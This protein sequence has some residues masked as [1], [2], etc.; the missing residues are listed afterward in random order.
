MNKI[1]KEQLDKI[2]GLPPY[3]DNTT[4]LIIPKSSTNPNDLKIGN[5]YVLKLAVYI[6]NPPSGFLLADQWNKGIT[7]KSE[8]IRCEV[9]QMMGKMIRVGAIGYDIDTDTD[10]TDV[11]ESLWLPVSGVKIVRNLGAL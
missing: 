1:I 6:I 2:E 9:L 4:E 3:D 11:Y 10:K 7:P 8:Y 5:M